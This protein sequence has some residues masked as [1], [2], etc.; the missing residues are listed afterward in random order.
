MTPP[1]KRTVCACSECVK[2][3]HRQPGPLAAGDW[4]RIQA[5]LGIS[6]Q[7]MAD[8]FC[9]SPGALVMNRLGEV[10]RIGSIT[11]QRR[12]GR[13]VFLDEHDRCKIHEVAPAGCAYFDTHMGAAEAQYRGS[14]LAHSQEDPAYQS[15]RKQ[16]PYT[17]S[18]KPSGYKK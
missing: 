14:W 13:C 8:L 17:T 4:E 10:R 7:E 6:I 3:C 12:K 2:C 11:P 15:L 16:L 9:A 18:Y 1:F 5:H